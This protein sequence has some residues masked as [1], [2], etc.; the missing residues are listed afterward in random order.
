MSIFNFNTLAPDIDKKIMHIKQTGSFQLQ[1]CLNM[2]DLSMDIRR[3]RVNGYSR[4]V[5][6]YFDTINYRPFQISEVILKFANSSLL[7]KL[8][9]RLSPNYFL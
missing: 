6:R 8:F 2:Y 5:T 3:E 9:S 4:T 1:V 7:K